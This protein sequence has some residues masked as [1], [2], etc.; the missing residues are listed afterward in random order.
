MALDLLARRVVDPDLLV[1]HTFSLDE[2]EDAFR[3]LTDPQQT[4][5]KVVTVP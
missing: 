1:S 3:T 5:V 4:V 2:Y